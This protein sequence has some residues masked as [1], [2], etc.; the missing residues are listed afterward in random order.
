MVGSLLGSMSAYLYICDICIVY[1]HHI[2]VSPFLYCAEKKTVV[3]IVTIRLE[4]FFESARQPP[5]KKSALQTNLQP[6]DTKLLWI[7]SNTSCALCFPGAKTTL[8]TII[9]H[10]RA[11]EMVTFTY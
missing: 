8:S 10:L 1:T 11:R 7:F 2:P 6:K 3:A 5:K 9:S 4:N